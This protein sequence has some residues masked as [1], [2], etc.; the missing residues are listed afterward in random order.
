MEAEPVSVPWAAQPGETG[1]CEELRWDRKAPGRGWGRLFLSS[2]PGRKEFPEQLSRQERCR[3]PLSSD[4][5][6]KMQEGIP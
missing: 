4:P 3:N 2:Y 5:S 1:M 6:R